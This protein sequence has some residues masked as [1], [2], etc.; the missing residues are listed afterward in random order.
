MEMK[1][2]THIPLTDLFLIVSCAKESQH[3]T[4]RSQGR[5]DNVR[6][7]F[8][9]LLI[10]KVRQILSGNIGM[11]GKVVVRSVGN[12]PQLAPAEGEQELNIRS[13]FGIEGKLFL[14]MV[15]DTHFFRFDSQGLQPVDTELLP[16][17]KPFQISVGLTEEFQL[18]LLKFTGTEGK[19]SGSDFVTEGFAHLADAEGNLLSGGTLYVFEVHKN[20]LCGF[21]TKVN[22]ILRILGNALEGLEHQ[23][24][25]TDIRKIMFAAARAGNVM[26]FNEIHHFFLIPAVNGAVQLYAVVRSVIFNYFVRTETLVA[27]LTVH[28]RIGKA[29]QMAAGHPCLRV[30][31]NGAVNTHIIRISGDEFLP[32]CLLHIIFQLHAQVAVIPCIGKASVNFGPG[33]YKASRFGQSHNFFHCLFHFFSSC[34]IRYASFYLNMI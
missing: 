1:H 33:V 6:N 22:R 11:L 16:V 31:E 14:I 34:F 13:R 27:F 2:G 28:Q 26:F 5:F 12:A 8:D 24:K 3:N 23:V 25:L 4:V 18:H 30:H 9:I 7:I 20:T 21:R 29:A 17:S 15:T 19:V 32:P 10:V